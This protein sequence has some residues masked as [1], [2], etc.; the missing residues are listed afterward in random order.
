V[1]RK[2]EA[3]Q[4][5]YEAFRKRARARQSALRKWRRRKSRLLAAVGVQTEAEFQNRLAI[6]RQAEELRGERRTL[7]QEIALVATG[8][9]SEEALGE[10]L[11]D[12]RARDLE[13]HRRQ[14]IE[15]QQAQAERL[16]AMHE[17][18][19]QWTQQLRA[20][21]AD[22][23]L[24]ARQMELGFVERQLTEAIGRW[25][26][27]GV[28]QSLLLGVR[29]RY[30]AERQPETLKA[31]SGYLKRMTAGQYRRIWTPLEGEVLFVDDREGRS[32]S[33]EVLSRGT[34]EQLFLALRLAL[35]ASFA[36][37]GA[38][39]PM[40]LDD[41]LVNF[42]AHRA[43]LAAE[44][45]AEFAAEGRQVLVF[46]C[47]DHMVRLFTALQAD[48]R[49]LP[50]R[51]R[52]PEAEP[53]PVA[54]DEPVVITEPPPEPE[55]P[56]TR[57]LVDVRLPAK[58]PEWFEPLRVDPPAPPPEPIIRWERQTGP[59]PFETLLWQEPPES[60]RPVALRRRARSAAANP[61][62][63]AVSGVGERG[64]AFVDDLWK[65]RGE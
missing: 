54:L 3:I 42:D 13:T 32:L 31:A 37:R 9:I 30:E 6:T 56:P 65:D 64:E 2:R 57:T 15:L 49:R 29:R 7:S 23:R 58:E 35:V 34:R 8:E 52:L 4:A 44:V 59:S 11:D 21:E 27:L 61:A 5:E 40:V 47:H 43:R 14:A 33:V 24:P 60:S 38:A 55:T 62:A 28:A 36:R 12:G 1:A 48:A 25:Q 39:L 10:L 46:T 16:R 41:V 45:I 51:G 50:H 53:E 26:A 19:G 63:G 22:V 20:L 17:Q 18:S